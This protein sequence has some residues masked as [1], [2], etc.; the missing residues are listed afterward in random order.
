MT[1][2]INNSS[3]TNQLKLNET[4]SLYLDSLLGSGAFGKIYK[5]QNKK[6][7]Q[8][9]AVKLESHTTPN[10]QLKHEYKILSTIQNL[11][12]IPKIYSYLSLNTDE[13]LIM[14]ML[15]ANLDLILSKTHDKK[16]SMKSS[17][18][19]FSQGLQR[20]RDLH[21]KGLIHRDLKPEN[22][23]IGLKPKERTIYLIDFGLSKQYI[24]PKTKNHIQYKDNRPI[25]GT[26]RYISLNAHKGIELSRRDD[27]EGL[28]YV[29]C[30]F[31]MGQLPWQGVKGKSDKERTQKIFEKK[32]ETVPNELCKYFPEEIK[33][34]FEHILKLGFDEKPNYV[35]LQG[36]INDLM[37]KYSYSNDLKFDWYT[38][39][40]LNELYEGTNIDNE[41][42]IKNNK[43]LEDLNKNNSN[44]NKNN[45]N[46]KNNKNNNNILLDEEKKMSKNLILIGN[47][48]ILKPNIKYKKTNTTTNT[49]KNVI[50]Y[51]NYYSNNV[52]T[53]QSKQ[54]S[55]NLVRSSLDGLDNI[56][57]YNQFNLHPVSSNDLRSSF[58]KNN[59][60]FSN[61]PKNTYIKTSKSLK[62]NSDVK[63]NV[64]KQY[65]NSNF[66]K[67]SD[68]V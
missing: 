59:S 61:T 50:N 1:N 21:E 13:A 3:P 63:K 37:N 24:D 41:I 11:T 40:F 62:D 4:Y 19:F 42:N 16:F 60:K 64:N 65:K 46:I 33:R 14:E 29:V 39:K 38:P 51:D 8:I 43:I 27:L 49:N 66:R 2:N 44:E 45:N 48:V 6:N 9:L 31:I 22:F 54:L 30:Y 34:Y 32:K 68:Y 5:C 36:L 23:V 25:L 35:L 57:L 15:G 56:K 20:L 17:L 28:G 18:M 58:N 55:N 7:A 47:E 26:V 10:P 52:E 12:G 53:K 67:F